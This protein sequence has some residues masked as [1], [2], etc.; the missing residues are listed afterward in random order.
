MIKQ[1]DGWDESEKASHF[2]GQEIWDPSKKPTGH[3]HGHH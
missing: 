3:G 2:P 1:K